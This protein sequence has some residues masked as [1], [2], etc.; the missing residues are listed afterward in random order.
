MVKCLYRQLSHQQT[1]RPPQPLQGES[2]QTH[3]P[4]RP[5]CSDLPE[6]GKS[7]VSWKRSGLIRPHAAAGSDHGCLFGRRWHSWYRCSVKRSS[8]VIHS[9]YLRLCK[10]LSGVFHYE[11]ACSSVG[12][13]L[14]II[15]Q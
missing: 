7:R 3:R 11:L 13:L 14:G 10:S 6:L 1:K 5:V 9:L 2:V 12:L 8:A 4:I 15:K